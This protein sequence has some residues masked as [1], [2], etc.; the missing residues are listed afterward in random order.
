MAKLHMDSL[1]SKLHRRAVRDALDS[2][3]T[4][5]NATYD[6]AMARIKAQGKDALELA[7]RVLSWIICAYRPLSLKELQHAL[8][9]SHD[10]TSM[11]L[12]AIVDEVILTSV[13]GGLVVIDEN[14]N[15]I[16]LVRK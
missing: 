1:A 10:M 13:C 5:V 8:A 11:D 16:R 7:E 6:E 12:E 15:V 9:V 3:P 4:E 2:L 14:S